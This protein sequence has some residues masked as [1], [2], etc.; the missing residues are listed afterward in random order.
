M[1]LQKLEPIGFVKS[2][3][4]NYPQE[5]PR[6][7]VFARNSGV[8]ELLPGHG[9]EQALEDLGGFERIWLIFLFDRNGGGWK[10]KVRPPDGSVHKRGVFATRS[11]HRPN[12]LGISAVELDRI[13]GRK[14][15]I[16]N[17]DL[18]DGT[19]IL[20]IKPY[21][22]AA[23]AFPNARAGWR[24]ENDQTCRPVAFSPE[25]AADAA[26]IRAHGGPDLENTARVQLGTRRPDAR[27]QRLTDLPDPDHHLLAFR[28]WRIEFQTTGDDA[29]QVIAI[30]SGYT[31]EELIPD[32]PDPYRDKEL[33]RN[34]RLS[35]TRQQ[36][37][38]LKK[39]R[40]SP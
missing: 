11:P 34:F 37:K 29:V 30:T 22:P 7:A 3:G 35:K 26:W 33:H 36:T 23:D 20:D 9:Y 25:A 15:F 19:P 18:L 27:R 6:Q 17:F 32:A 14:L 40:R 8:I 16:R 21:I 2:G 28:T 4:G 5:A 39:N 31:D 1:S 24:D 13:E 10:P 38:K 12:P